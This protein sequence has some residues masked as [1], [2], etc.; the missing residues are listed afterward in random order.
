[1]PLFVASA[2]RC[3]DRMLRAPRESHRLNGQENLRGSLCRRPPYKLILRCEQPQ[4]LDIQGF[5]KSDKLKIENTAN[6]AF[7]FCN[8]RP[9]NRNTL[10]REPF[11]EFRLRDRGLGVASRLLYTFADKVLADLCHQAAR[12]PGW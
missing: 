9:V 3:V 1:M 5:G 7:N 10:F 4:D 8:T 12:L 11:G 6:P 2:A